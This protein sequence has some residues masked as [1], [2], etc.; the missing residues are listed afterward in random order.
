MEIDAAAAAFEYY[1]R[2]TTTFLIKIEKLPTVNG[3]WAVNMLV[4][5]I[6]ASKLSNVD[7]I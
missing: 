1:N 6:F 4:S 2:F 3:K 5:Y 7:L